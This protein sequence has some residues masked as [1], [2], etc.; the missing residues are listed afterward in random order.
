MYPTLA[1]LR[2]IT[3][4]RT[5]KKKQKTILPIMNGKEAFKLI[6]T[7]NP[8]QKIIISS[9]YSLNEDVQQLLNK[10]AAGFIQKPFR[11]VELVDE[12]N[13]VLNI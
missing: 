4:K 6:R 2:D 1:T 7:K 8:D 3:E 13:R 12:I 5:L 9:G 11:K 10:G